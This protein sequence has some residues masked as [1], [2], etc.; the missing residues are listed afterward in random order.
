MPEAAYASAGLLG[1]FALAGAAL[2]AAREVVRWIVARTP[3]RRDDQALRDVE[4]WLERNPAAV[5]LV[6]E[7]IRRL[8][9]RP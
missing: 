2:R 9:G 7:L 8:R 5:E 6:E 4:R 1:G 3:T